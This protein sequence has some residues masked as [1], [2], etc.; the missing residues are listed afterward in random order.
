MLSITGCR[1]SMPFAWM[2]YSGWSGPN[3][4]AKLRPNI[5]TP[6]RP[7]MKNSGGFSPEVWTGTSMR[8]LPRDQLVDF[9]GTFLDGRCIDEQSHRHGDSECLFDFDEDARRQH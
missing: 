9:A 8:L 6:R 3:T 7:C 2:A 5:M 1:P 4:R